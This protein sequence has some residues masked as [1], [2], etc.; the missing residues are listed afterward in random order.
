MAMH[1]RLPVALPQDGR[2]EHQGAAAGL[3]GFAVADALSVPA[4]GGNAVA[5]GVEGSVHEF[6]N[7]ESVPMGCQ[8]LVK[9]IHQSSAAGEP[10]D[11]GR[12]GALD[13]FDAV[14]L[15]RARMRDVRGHLSS[16]RR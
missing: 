13:R 10:L 15:Q 5:D 9:F 7:A 12:R 14:C 3:P 11:D 6:G 2:A 1:E 4:V 16:R 8:Q